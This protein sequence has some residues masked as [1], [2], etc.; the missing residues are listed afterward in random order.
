MTVLSCYLPGGAEEYH[1][2][3]S[4]DLVPRLRMRG[5]IPLLPTRLHDVVLNS[6]P[7]TILPLPCNYPIIR[8]RSL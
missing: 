3:V 5:A 2:N 6:A 7:G 8:R 1:E 4:Q